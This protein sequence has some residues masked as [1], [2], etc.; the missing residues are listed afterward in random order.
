MNKLEEYVKKSNASRA[1]YLHAEVEEGK[2]LD[3]SF[4]DRLIKFEQ[5]PIAKWYIIKA[6][7]LSKNLNQLE[8]L[9]DVG[10]AVDTEIRKTSLHRIA[11]WSIGQLGSATLKSV[12]QRY[13]KAEHDYEKAFLIDAIGEIGDARAVPFL[14]RAFEST[15][16]KVRMWT[17]LSLAKLGEASL[18]VLHDLLRKEMPL[19]SRLL[20]LDALDKLAHPSSGTIIAKIL[21]NGSKDEVCFIKTRQLDRLLLGR[22]K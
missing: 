22:G 4:L 16:F 20:L 7:G 6:V 12:I 10:R 3:S 5:N 1:A 18:P 17:A 19:A 15:G 11:A 21:K 14:A 8:F 9:L 13:E 2:G